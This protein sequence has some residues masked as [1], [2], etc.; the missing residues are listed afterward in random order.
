MNFS[1]QEFQEFKTE[2]LELP[3]LAE[4]SLQSHTHELET[5][6]VRFKDSGS[7]PAPYISLF[8][9]GID[10]ART[11]LDGKTIE[12]AHKRSLAAA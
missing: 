7:I 1:E 11:I 4:K 6:L 3:E 12:E 10:V 5:M 8:L 9:R 2:A